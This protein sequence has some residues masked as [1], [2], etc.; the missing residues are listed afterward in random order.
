MRMIRMKRILRALRIIVFFLS[1]S[2]LARAEDPA[3]LN[4]LFIAVDD[5]KPNLGCYG[6]TLALTPHMDAIAA[7][8]TVFTSNYCQQAV[9]A[10][11]RASLLT[12]RY[13]D[14]IRVWDLETQLR[15]L[16]PGIV[17]LPQYMRAS[18]Y[19]TAATGKV[20]DPRS[21][22]D[23]RDSP[24]WS[25]PYRGSWDIKYYDDTSGRPAAYF[26]ASP[27]AKDTIALLEAEAAA[28]GID[29]MEYVRAH[30]FPA[31]EKADVPVDAY[32]DGAVANAGIELLEELAVGEAPF[33][34]AVGFHRPHLP[35]NAPSAFWDLYDRSE[36]SLA[37]FREKAQGSP[38]IG[39]HNY[40]ELRSYTGIPQTG[41][42]P[43]ETQLELI[44]G[45]Y[46]AVSYI[47]YLVGMLIQRLDELGLANRTAI[48]LW[49]DH[50]WHLGDHDLWCKHSN[51]E[52]ATR[53]PLIISIPGQNNPGGRVDSP[54]EFTD[55]ASTICEM[56]S[57]PIP[58]FF[59]GESLLPL[60]SDPTLMIREGSLSQY[61]RGNRMGY[62]LRTKRYRY[63]KWVNANGSF[64]EDEL[65]DYMMDPLETVDYSE[66]TEYESV[67]Q[68]MDGILSVRITHP[69]TQNRIRFLV[70]GLNQD[71]DTM[72][73]NDAVVRFE[74]G[75]YRTDSQGSALVT[76]PD[77]VFPY[78]IE[79]NGYDPNQGTLTI[80]GDTLIQVFMGP[81]DLEVSVSVFNYYTGEGITGIHVTLNGFET[82]TD[83][84]GRAVIFEK[85]G[86]YLLFLEHDLFGDQ[87]DTV[88]LVRDTTLTVTLKPSHSNVQIILSEENV[89]MGYT[90][91]MFDT[92]TRVTNSWGI[93]EF[94]NVP[95]QQ[96][97]PW[98]VEKEGY[99]SRS[100][101]VYLLTDTAI[102][103]QMEK[104]SSAVLLHDKDEIAVWP[105]P[106]KELLH[107][108]LPGP[109]PAVLKMY[110]L[111]GRIL[112]NQIIF[113]S[114]PAIDLCS[115][116][117]G[118]Y[119]IVIDTPGTTLVRLINKI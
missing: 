62:S 41:P 36:F 24:S 31:F 63:T 21:V 42:L 51:F 54:T 99:Q 118:T 103:V 81:P 117:Q 13:P 61:P 59:E 119:L 107:F 114:E 44:H 16:N 47:D 22:D 43:E 80:S 77:G 49:G 109:G 100:G 35:F 5:L 40:A 9:C 78:Q 15:E 60:I 18:G 86:S 32:S 56:T 34:L 93:A 73:L 8:G 58:S 17:T 96:P 1:V 11:S 37:P 115:L 90:P 26:Y 25:I 113:D 28:L 112:F 67:V 105:N 14:Q 64:Y 106:V 82:V 38:D 89:P 108:Q 83:T 27:G 52:Q 110:T 55:I 87:A 46:A 75:R 2:Q 116:D 98:M 20:F 50:G 10:P 65:Y 74:G 95:T 45:Y 72:Q 29:A 57:M 12:G 111:S 39:Y 48:V 101:S 3:R 92:M 53:S 88:N 23:A 97:Y 91:V 102:S 30:Y 6:D 69:S 4:V 104:L 94:N 7:K 70:T 68:S 76:H 84:E 66:A 19:E 85:Q 79:A 33:F 71:G